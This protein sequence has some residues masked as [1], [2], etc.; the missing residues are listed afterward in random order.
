MR[1]NRKSLVALAIVVGVPAA[2]A[3]TLVQT[4]LEG[5]RGANIVC[6]VSQYLPPEAKALEPELVAIATSA[7][8]A[9][10]LKAVSTS[11][12]YL[13]I[14]V[15]GEPVESCPGKYL[16]S[17]RVAFKEPVLLKR[18]PEQHIPNSSSLA[19][20][21]ASGAAVVPEADLPAQIRES[22]RS[23]VEYF[24]EIVQRVNRSAASGAAR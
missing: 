20:W 1:V 11:D 21:E 14:D 8:A 7:L 9:G 5:V 22:V 17:I 19:T 2:Q 3:S 10:G 18:A 6:F 15:S 16:L 12:Q 4:Q 13:V 23:R 24:V